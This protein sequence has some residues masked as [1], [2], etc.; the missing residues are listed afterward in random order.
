MLIGM[1]RVIHVVTHHGSN[2]WPRTIRIYG[3]HICTPQN[4]KTHGS[5]TLHNYLL[6][7]NAWSSF[8]S[9]PNPAITD[10]GGLSPRPT[11][12]RAAQFTLHIPQ[13][14]KLILFLQR[15]LV[16]GRYEVD[17]V[18]NNFVRSCGKCNCCKTSASG[19]RLLSRENGLG[20]QPLRWLIYLW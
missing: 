8:R 5:L 19:I 18:M 11:G 20:Q 14:S 3:E 13:G 15:G 2:L 6:P 16:I 7:R 4:F 1:V 10:L 9:T 17:W 12:E